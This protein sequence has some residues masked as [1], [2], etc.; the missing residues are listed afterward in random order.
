[1]ERFATLKAGSVTAELEQARASRAAH[2]RPA[3]GVAY[4]APRSEV[5]QRI[6]AVWQEILG[7]EEVGIE[8]NFFDLGGDSL[9]A[10]QLS[11]RLRDAFGVEPS[12]AGLFESPTVTGLAVLIAQ[13]LAAQMDEGALELMLAELEQ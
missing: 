8:D 5:E 13:N 10:L 3:L 6:A 12:L 1:V 7:I 9:V 2:P 4:V 11:S